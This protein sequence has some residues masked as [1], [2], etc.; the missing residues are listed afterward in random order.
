VSQIEGTEK[1]GICGRG[2]ERKFVDLPFFRHL[3]FAT[4]SENATVFECVYCHTVQTPHIF[5]DQQKLFRSIEYQRTLDSR[6]KSNLNSSKKRW[7]EA[8][9]NLMATFINKN[10]PRIL[11]IGCSDGELLLQIGK[12]VPDS[13]L[14]GYDIGCSPRSVEVI[15]RVDKFCEKEEEALC[16]DFDLV[17]YSHSIA[18][19]SDIGEH[20]T[21]LREKLCLSS[22]IV[23][24]APNI[25]ENH[26]Y[27]LMGDQAYLYAPTTLAN[28]LRFHGY[29][30][31]FISVP[32]F[33]R[34]M[35]C[36][37]KPNSNSASSP[38][39]NNN[40]YWTAVEWGRRF[41]TALTECEGKSPLGVLGTT[42]NGAFVEAILGPKLDFFVDE[43]WTKKKGATFREKRVIHPADLGERDHVLVP[44]GRHSVHIMNRLRQEYEGKFFHLENDLTE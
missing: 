5:K 6:R 28:T 23:I 17:V 11:D 44:Y 4:I 12:I 3:D 16:M 22:Q 43:N 36:I 8:Q 27:S 9:A 30:P 33:P 37:G 24:Q 32:E 21:K 18:Y 29:Q 41:S 7:V 1:C 31:K 38:M 39:F 19:I 15:S 25:N 26:M 10:A 42:I 13:I 2:L 34:E 40:E 35:L 20:L 14:V